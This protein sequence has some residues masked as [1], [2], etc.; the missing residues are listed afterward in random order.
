MSPLPKGSKFTI[1]QSPSATPRVQLP[2]ATPSA[3]SP[4]GQ[5]SASAVSAEMVRLQRE[6][7]TVEQYIERK[8]RELQLKIA[9]LQTH[10]PD[11][12]IQRMQ[13]DAIV[14]LYYM[15]K[16]IWESEAITA[17]MLPHNPKNP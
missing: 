10:R 9:W 5:P 15:V 3:A 2:G 11:D 4:I 6:K 12:E 16:G 1:A 8:E 7:E 17:S 14:G 13:S